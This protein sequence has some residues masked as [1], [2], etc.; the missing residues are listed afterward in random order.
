M[1]P[2][3][4]WRVDLYTFVPEID[5][6]HREISTLASQLSE[7]FAARKPKEEVEVPLARFI[8]VVERHFALE[9]AVMLSRG[10][11]G[12]EV[13]KGEH[14]KLLEQIDVLAKELRSGTIDPCVAL[15]SFIEI[16]TEQHM[17]HA[18][19]QLAKFLKPTP[20]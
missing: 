3:A 12:Y 10:Y 20:K 16:W 1:S 17:L 7:A 8:T 15:V 18:D 11:E 19:K 5:R 9:E 13:H 14:T 2:Q 4:R 6:Q